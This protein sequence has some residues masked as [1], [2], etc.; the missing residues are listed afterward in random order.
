MKKLAIVLMSFFLMQCACKRT[1]DT[2]GP[3]SCP[4]SDFKVTTPLVF[5][6]NSGGP[7]S[8]TQLNLMN[9]FAKVTAT[10]NENISYT[11]TIKGLTSGAEFIMNSS[12]SSIDYNWYGNS[13]N[14]LY[15]KQNEVLVYTLS[16]VCK[17]EPLGQGEIKLTTIVGYTG[18]GLKVINFEDSPPVP[19]GP[20]GF[21]TPPLNMTPSS[22]GY[23]AS[24][25]GQNYRHYV[26]TSPTT[27]P[28]WYFGGQGFDGI[29]FTSLGTDPTKVYLNF[30]AK[31]TDNSQCGM[32]F[33]E[34]SHGSLLNRKF[35]ANVSPTQWKLYS[36]KLSEIGIINP[37][38]IQNLDFNLGAATVPANRVEVDLD[39]VIFTLNEPF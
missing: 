29:N 8:T 1:T 34:L 17:K 6:D 28:I 24:P 20:Y 21:T 32:M 19:G 22:S 16:N 2:L 37:A 11:L 30:F 25:Q 10:F 26:G 7:N 35:L 38:A 4:T 36:V 23:I 5:K 9:S 12:G 3:E 18:F 27:T 14:R 13:T 39:L 15:F 33:K 31:G